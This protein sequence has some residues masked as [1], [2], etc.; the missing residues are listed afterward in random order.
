MALDP[1]VN[2][3]IGPNNIYRA[4]LGTGDLPTTAISQQYNPG[5][6]VISAGGSIGQIQCV[7][8]GS[9][10][11]W[12]GTNL[13]ATF[14]LTAA[15][16]I[17]MNGT[18][19]TI[20]AAPGTGKALIPALIM[21]EMTTTSTA[22]TGGGAVEFYYHGTTTNV[23]TGTIP[24]SVVTAAAGT[25]YTLLGPAAATNGTTVLANTGIDITNA[26]AAFAAGTGTAKIEILYNL[27]S[28]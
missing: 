22:F 4:P 8:G 7:V 20:L 21:F 15:N 17:A 18:P 6:V 10:P 25:S 24:A 16:I 23:V 12:I 9:A 13:L 11:T 14:T 5:D 2:Q 26:T 3:L 27:I 28:L 19:I 1:E